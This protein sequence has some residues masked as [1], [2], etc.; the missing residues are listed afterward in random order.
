MLFLNI[1]SYAR[2]DLWYII[3]FLFYLSYYLVSFLITSIMPHYRKIYRPI[4]VYTLPFVL[5]SIKNVLLSYH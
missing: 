1:F 3:S 5:F 2:S 4:A